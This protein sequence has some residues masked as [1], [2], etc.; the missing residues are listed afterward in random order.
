MN[1]NLFDN[2][3]VS[4]VDNFNNNYVRSTAEATQQRYNSVVARYQV[5]QLTN[6]RVIILETQVRI[7]SQRNK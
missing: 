4:D 2:N 6:Q 3:N 7:T 1:F 5:I